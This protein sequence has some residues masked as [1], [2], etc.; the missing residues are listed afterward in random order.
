MR[1]RASST[2]TLIS[3][4]PLGVALLRDPIAFLRAHPDALLIHQSR[5]PRLSA[6]RLSELQKAT[7]EAPEFPKR[8]RFAL[9]L[10]GT[11]GGELCVK[12]RPQKML[13]RLV[14]PLHA[15]NELKRH[16]EVQRRAFAATRPIGFGSSRDA[17]GHFWQYFAQEV[18]SETAISGETIL[19]EPLEQ[20]LGIVAAELAKLHQADIFHGDLKPYHVVVSAQAEHWLYLDLDPVRFGVTRRQR[21]INLYQGL[22]YFLDADSELIAPLVQR[23]CEHLEAQDTKFI[24]EL[25]QATSKLFKR[26]METHRGPELST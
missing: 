8:K 16:Q 21:A 10:S 7:V 22:R 25:T 18:L 11:S 26:K 4:S 14:G 3:S 19:V 24:A 23:Y 6:L 12:L 1:R 2:L 17:K 5:D 15:R 20:R 13:E 9:R